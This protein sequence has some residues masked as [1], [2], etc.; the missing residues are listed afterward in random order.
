MSWCESV[1]RPHLSLWCQGRRTL[2]SPL[3]TA[4]ASR[5]VSRSTTKRQLGF[6]VRSIHHPVRASLRPSSVS[7]CLALA[8]TG[9][10]P[11]LND[12]PA[13][14]HSPLYRCLGFV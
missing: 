10:R 9:A 2:C 5:R 3:A 6:I 8:Q 11:T 14:L 12:C 7:C 1:F 4:S 13:E